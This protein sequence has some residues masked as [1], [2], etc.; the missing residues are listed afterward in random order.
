M[1]SYVVWGIDKTKNMEQFKNIPEHRKLIIIVENTE[2]KFHFKKIKLNT[3]E[4][5]SAWKIKKAKKIHNKTRKKKKKK[6]RK[7]NNCNE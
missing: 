6:E 3:N 7:L 4:L 2:I 5:A 1:S